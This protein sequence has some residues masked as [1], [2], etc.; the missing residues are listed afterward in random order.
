MF[1]IT[2]KL[3]SAAAAG[4][5]F[6]VVGALDVGAATATTEMELAAVRAIRDSGVRL[7]GGLAMASVMASAAF[8]AGPSELPF[9]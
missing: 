9:R 4:G 8:G 3:R 1:G 2:D 7:R 6:A 5:L